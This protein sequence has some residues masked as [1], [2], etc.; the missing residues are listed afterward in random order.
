MASVL[1][2]GDESFTLD[3]GAD[4]GRLKKEIEAASRQGGGWVAVS[5]AKRRAW[6]CVSPGQ[7]IRLVEAE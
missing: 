1:H 4:V 5:G 2:W 3:E 7:Y 6:I